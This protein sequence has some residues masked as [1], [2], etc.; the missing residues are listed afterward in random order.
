MER[1]SSEEDN[2]EVEEEKVNIHTGIEIRIRHD[3]NGTMKEP[4][5]IVRHPHSIVESVGKVDTTKLWVSN[6]E[7]DA[8]IYLSDKQL[9]TR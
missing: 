7:I 3:D 1:P 4:L 5:S 2:S 8:T 6:K 9:E